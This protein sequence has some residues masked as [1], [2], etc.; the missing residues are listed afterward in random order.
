MWGGRTH[1]GNQHFSSVTQSV[2]PTSV[3]KGDCGGC[4]YGLVILSS[5]PALNPNP[6]TTDSTGMCMRNLRHPSPL[7]LRLRKPVITNWPAYVPVIVLDWPAASRPTAQIKVCT[8]QRSMAQQAMSEGRAKG[9]RGWETARTNCS[10][11]THFKVLPPL[12]P[13]P[14]NTESKTCNHCAC[15]MRPRDGAQVLPRILRLDPLSQQ[16][17]CLLTATKTSVHPPPAT[18][19]GAQVLL[20]HSQGHPPIRPHT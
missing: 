14:S 20:L 10:L 17:P 18:Q 2:R 12:H 19:N 5:K 9:S 7:A 16:P 6:T 13:P 4:A 3:Y 15:T 8:A 11:E 1:G